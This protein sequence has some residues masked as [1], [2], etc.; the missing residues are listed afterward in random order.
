M[1]HGCEWFYSFY[2]SEVKVCFF[3]K[4]WLYHFFPPIISLFVLVMDMFVYSE[5]TVCTCGEYCVCGAEF[6]VTLDC[7]CCIHS[8]IYIYSPTC[9]FASDKIKKKKKNRTKKMYVI[10]SEWAA[11]C[12]TLVWSCFYTH[13]QRRWLGNEGDRTI[14]LVL[15]SCDRKKRGK[16]IYKHRFCAQNLC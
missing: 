13:P 15:W 11:A 5:Y 16:T 4:I 14:F 10:C 3:L 9:F 8:Y 6:C 2:L 7:M 12:K 1:Y